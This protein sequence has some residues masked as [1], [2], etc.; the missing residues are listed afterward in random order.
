MCR[1]RGFRPAPGGG[2]EAIGGGA[3]R[4]RRVRGRRGSR[5]LSLPRAVGRSGRS[6]RGL[7]ASPRSRRCPDS[8]PPAHA[9]LAADRSG[10]RHARRADGRPRSGRRRAARARSASR[11]VTGRWLQGRSMRGVDTG[12][13]DDICAAVRLLP[14]RLGR[15]VRPSFPS[16]RDPPRPGSASGAQRRCA[17]MKRAAALT[18]SRPSGAASLLLRY[19]A[20]RTASAASLLPSGLAATFRAPAAS[21]RASS[22][23]ASATAPRITLRARGLNASPTP[24]TNGRNTAGL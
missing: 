8:E 7:R 9:C 6:R 10:A 13:F 18:R 12:A 23:R 21:S 3:T 5:K 1:G 2:S 16:G 24:R 14:A 20:A 11:T 19:E 15:G 17:A 4:A 22:L